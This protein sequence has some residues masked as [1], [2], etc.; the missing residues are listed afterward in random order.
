MAD[1]GDLSPEDRK[2]LILDLICHEMLL[3]E[4][5]GETPRLEEYL[6]RFPLLH[7]D[8]K[9]QSQIDDLLRSI[10]E[11]TVSGSTVVSGGGVEPMPD[12]TPNRIGRYNIV[13]Q[14]GRGATG[15]VY[16][17]FDPD[18]KRTVALKKL[19]AGLDA[20]KDELARMRAESEAVAKIRHPHVVQVYDVGIDNGQPY[21]TMELCRGGSLKSRLHGDPISPRQVAELAIQLAHALAAAHAARIIHRDLK[22]ENI[23]LTDETTW[24]VK[25]T[26]FGLAKI[27]DSNVSAT[28]SGC[29]IGTPAY[30][31]PEQ[32]F[33]DG[34]NVGPAADIYAMGAIL[35]ECLTGTPPFRGV[36]VQETLAQVR[37]HEAVSLRQLAPAVPVDLE[38][39]AHKCLQKE[40]NRRYLSAQELAE[41]LERYCADK[42][43]RARKISARERIWRVCRRNPV[44]AMMSAAVI[45]L[46]LG[47]ILSLAWLNSI[48]RSKNQTVSIALAEK[49][50]SFNEKVRALEGRE[51]ALEAA[52]SSEVLA[53]RRFYAAQLNLANEAL[54]QK[55]TARADL[56]LD[57]V[58]P[59]DGQEDLRGFEWHMLRNELNQHLLL[60][61]DGHSLEVT[62]LSA[63]PDG[64]Q[65]LVG[66]G[67]QYSGYYYIVDSET[68][69][70]V[71]E[72]K[73]LDCILHGC[74]YDSKRSQFVLAHGNG[75][76]T[77]FDSQT[78]ANQASEK[79]STL[80][81]SMCISPDSRW[82]AG[83]GS[84]GDLW[85]MDLETS[86]STILTKAHRS[87]P[88]LYSFF[89]SD[90]KQLYTA[91][92]WGDEG[93]ISRRWSMEA[94]PP[95]LDRDFPSI[96]LRDVSPDGLV[97]V[98]TDWGKLS[99]VATKDG[100]VIH[101]KSV[102]TGAIAGALFIDAEHLLV[103]TRTDRVVKKLDVST[104]DVTEAYSMRNPVMALALD[105]EHGTWASGDSH[106]DVRVWEEEPSAQTRRISI[107]GAIVGKFL[108]DGERVLV[109]IEKG[110]S[111]IWN[112]ATQEVESIADRLNLRAW[113][114]NRAFELTESSPGGKKQ[115]EVWTKN[116]DTPR[117]VPFNGDIYRHSVAISRSGKW[118][119]LRAEGEDA[120]V[121]DLSSSTLEPRFRVPCLAFAFEFSPNNR[122]LVGGL[123]AG[124]VSCFDLEKG[125][126]RPNLKEW[127][128]FW[129]WGLSVAFNQD[130]S[131]VASGNES[132]AVRIWEVETGKLVN[133]VDTG[134]G[135]IMAIDFFPDN[136]RIA[137]GSTGNLMICDFQTNQELIRLPTSESQIVSLD[138]NNEGTAVMALTESGDMYCWKGGSN[139]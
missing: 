91:V 74:V 66:G 89:S 48:I 103:A 44:V 114:N 55:Q 18:L 97:A 63:S 19:R 115:F 14:I 77:H 72:N 11:R 68:G 137:V 111:R 86:E 41:D 107:P 88:I 13:K 84:E 87:A 70:V 26:D 71:H 15:V 79:T 45:A 73:R 34:K 76:L 119:A 42:P 8:L 82:M 138:V 94:W 102:S 23:M 122:W 16:E 134:Q 22:P 37:S 131:L 47:A 120:Q 95:T 109:G 12:E 90:S 96:V 28:L 104:L 139:N 25:V 17:A 125:E 50:L 75:L 124:I 5:A 135:E 65:W 85:V 108:E 118:L 27:L 10:L 130:G 69:R 53:N 80:F 36:T 136:R 67:N 20:T 113:S 64:K 116:S 56:L 132:G 92:E 1:Q 129:A 99:T 7:D 58:K 2:Q 128:S 9:L 78:F 126:L 121:Y 40:P 93:K 30:M 112:P 81:R 39:I 33:G 21:M 127:D 101:T 4:K 61:L 59:K 60:D 98:G 110:P 3:R 46:M 117:R 106:G 6:L 29:V 83:G 38:T 57:S 51:V 43:I 54:L 49:T 32:A 52:R 24:D 62:C 31:A 100:S 105:R 35:Y 133:Q 123:Q